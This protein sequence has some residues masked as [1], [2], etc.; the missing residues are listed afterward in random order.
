MVL[1]QLELLKEFNKP[2]EVEVEVSEVAVKPVRKR[3]KPNFTF[4]P[5]LDFIVRAIE[6]DEG[7]RARVISAFGFKDETEIALPSVPVLE[8]QRV[9]AEQPPAPPARQKKKAA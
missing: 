5:A 6:D 3:N 1:S 4:T 9:V 7:K 2:S 8:V